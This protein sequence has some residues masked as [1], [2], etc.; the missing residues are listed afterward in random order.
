MGPESTERVENEFGVLFMP[1]D[2]GRGVMPGFG[3]GEPP[4]VCIEI[5]YAVDYEFGYACSV[6]RNA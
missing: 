1:D 6:S 2:L 4:H 3:E 5:F